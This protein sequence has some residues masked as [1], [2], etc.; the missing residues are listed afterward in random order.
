MSGAVVITTRP[1]YRH[2]ELDRVL[3]PA[4]IAIIAASPKTGSFGERVL[5]NLAGHGR[6]SMRIRGKHSAC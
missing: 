3:N 4:S 1:L 6:T 5:A 2:A